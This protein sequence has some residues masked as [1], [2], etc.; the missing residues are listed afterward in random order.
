MINL[1]LP[2]INVKYMCEYK[3]LNTLRKYC[4]LAMWVLHF[5][6]NMNKHR[7]TLNKA[8]VRG[9]RDRERER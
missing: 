1:G 3:F 2:Y 5:V 9:E 7:I 6:L 4:K 8:S